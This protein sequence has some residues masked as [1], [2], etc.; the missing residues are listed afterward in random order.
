[1]ICRK[2]T[3]THVIPLRLYRY[4]FWNLL[5]RVV[6]MRTENFP[7]S[8]HVIPIADFEILNKT[9]KKRCGIPKHSNIELILYHRAIFDTQIR[10]DQ[11]PF[12]ICISIFIINRRKKIFILV[13]IVLNPSHRNSFTYIHY[14]HVSI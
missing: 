1:M 12:K 10:K 11:D 3:F 14:T 5:F 8:F 6:F 7:L 4:K 9:S 13:L 2:V